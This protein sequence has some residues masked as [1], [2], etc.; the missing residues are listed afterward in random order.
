MSFQFVLY[1]RPDLTKNYNVQMFL[2]QN[3]RP[4]SVGRMAMGHKDEKNGNQQE[5][6]LPLKFSVFRRGAGG[7]SGGGR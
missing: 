4:P 1:L 2:R 5:K 7:G 3:S 6:F